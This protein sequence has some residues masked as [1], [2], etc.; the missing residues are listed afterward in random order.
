MTTTDRP[1]PLLDVAAEVKTTEGA[2]M[3]ACTF[4]VSGGLISLNTGNLLTGLY[5]LLPGALAVLA[6]VL[7]ARRVATIGAQ[8]VTPSSDPKDNAGKRLVPEI[9]PAM[10]IVITGAGFS[11]ASTSTTTTV[12]GPVTLGPLGT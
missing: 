1:Q 10:P 7:G 6:A 3:G 2:V 12:S 5:G 11:P 4:L 8:S 9:P